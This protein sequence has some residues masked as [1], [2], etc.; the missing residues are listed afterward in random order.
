[1]GLQRF[2]LKAGIGV[3]G[4][5][6][7]FTDRPIR[8]LLVD[9]HTV[10]R[11]GLCLLIERQPCMT[12]VGETGSQE[13]AIEITR[14]EQPDI[15][16]LDT[17]LSCDHAC[18]IVSQF[19]DVANRAR[20]IILTTTR[21]PQAHR[22]AITFG[23]RGVVSKWES[24]GVLSKAIKRVLAGEIWLERST[25]ASL[26]FDALSSAQRARS[27][28]AKIALL[29]GREREVINLVAE[30][31]KNKPIADQL[32]ITESTVS[33]HLTSIFSKLGISDRLKLIVYAHRQGLTRPAT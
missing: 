18:A 23:A 12:V 4:S 26:L 33:H 15:I 31:L 14:R 3:V 13:D 27:E 10:V 21:D 8:I 7:M 1:M 22:R 24:S 25:T 19:L 30:G 29:T 32:F 2:G 9:A 16:L 17:N 28:A 5:P 6:V 20:V 11:E